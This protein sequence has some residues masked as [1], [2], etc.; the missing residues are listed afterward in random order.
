MRGR[1]ELVTETMLVAEIGAGG[2]FLIEDAF[3]EYVAFSID[4]AHAFS[5]AFGIEVAEIAIRAAK[6]VRGADF[7][8]EAVRRF[9]ALDEVDTDA[10]SGAITKFVEQ[11]V[12]IFEATCG[13]KIA[14]PVRATKLTTEAIA[15]AETSERRCVT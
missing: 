14:S 6:T 2:A 11:A 8:R 5:G 10:H 1:L 9:E 13:R 4:G 12:S 3:V 15:V 7:T